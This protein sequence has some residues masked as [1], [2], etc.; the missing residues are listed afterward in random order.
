[1]IHVVNRYASVSDCHKEIISKPKQ[2]A[3]GN[4]KITT[5]TTPITLDEEASSTDVMMNDLLTNSTNNNMYCRRDYM[6][7]HKRKFDQIEDSEG[8]I[9]LGGTLK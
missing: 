4:I 1:M 5:E 2:I 6:Y 9:Y 3:K 8:N 7:Y